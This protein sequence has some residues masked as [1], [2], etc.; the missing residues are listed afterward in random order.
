MI[1]SD[2]DDDLEDEASNNNNN[3]ELDAL[4]LDD[5]DKIRLE[6]KTELVLEKFDE[7]ALVALNEKLNDGNLNVVI[8]SHDFA[9]KKDNVA[10]ATETNNVFD[11]LSNCPR[12]TFD[13]ETAEHLRSD[14]SKSD[15]TQRKGDSSKP[16]PEKRIEKLLTPSLSPLKEQF[17]LQKSFENEKMSASNAQ[18]SSKPHE[19]PHSSSSTKNGF[20]N[21]PAVSMSSLSTAILLSKNK[22]TRADLRAIENVD[23]CS[24]VSSGE[25]NISEA[26]TVDFEID[27][28]HHKGNQLL[29]SLNRIKT[30]SASNAIAS[31]STLPQR[32][33]DRS[34]PAVSNHNISTPRSEHKSNEVLK[35][36]PTHT[37]SLDEPPDQTQNYTRLYDLY[38][39]PPEPIKPPMP[40]TANRTSN[41]TNL[42]ISSNYTQAHSTVSHRTNQVNSSKLIAENS[43]LAKEKSQAN[44]PSTTTTFRSNH[45]HPI[46]TAGTNSNGTKAKL[47]FDP[48]T[49]NESQRR[50]V[51]RWSNINEFN[52]SRE[53]SMDITPSTIGTLGKQSNSST[54]EKSKAISPKQSPSQLS[55][56]KKPAHGVDEKV[57]SM[58]TATS[59]NTSKRLIQIDLNKYPDNPSKYALPLLPKVAPAATE[60]VKLLVNQNATNTTQTTTNIVTPTKK[61]TNMSSAKQSSAVDDISRTKLAPLVDYDSS[62]MSSSSS[63]NS[64]AKSRDSDGKAR[65][66]RSTLVPPETTK[67]PP[68]PA[69]KKEQQHGSAKASV[70][71]DDAKTK[72][73]RSKCDS[74]RPSTS[75][76]YSSDSE[77]RTRCD[78]EKSIRRAVRAINGSLSDSDVRKLTAKI[79]QMIKSYPRNVMNGADTSGTSES[80][81]KKDSTSEESVRENTKEKPNRIKKRCH[82]VNNESTELSRELEELIDRDSFH[83]V[84]EPLP[85]RRRKSVLRCSIDADSSE[86]LETESNSAVVHPSDCPSTSSNNTSST[87]RT[88][89]HEEGE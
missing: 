85:K 56:H 12:S 3:N 5:L 30:S 19:G 45:S 72:Q 67:M 76:K 10:T 8:G 60:A 46:H 35:S 78:K 74:A 25:E 55:N 50:R 27:E 34:T 58:V 33:H 62:S 44:Q 11:I 64:N 68:G 79:V 82:D 39:R 31:N 36:L 15:G 84:P 49:P 26:T 42:T 59:P 51:S 9:R 23:G 81:S 37:N 63:S 71:K 47:M 4:G 87:S 69:S 20:T 41:S 22:S 14:P 17:V 29:K 54:K 40:I 88:I 65:K 16:L 77:K 28:N 53:K 80:L 21:Q 86:S 6:I 1:A 18:R 70:N 61:P 43:N 13:E 57:M 48:E 2:S 24:E 89:R 73:D 7:M 32:A 75:K 66:N 52:L 38:V 83:Y